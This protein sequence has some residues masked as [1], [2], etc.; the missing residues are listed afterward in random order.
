LALTP[1]A[2][3]EQHEGGRDRDSECEAERE[4][5]RTDQAAS[6]GR[7][8]RTTRAGRRF[9]QAKKAGRRIGGVTG[10]VSQV[11]AGLISVSRSERARV[12][13]A[14][15]SRPPWIS[16]TGVWTRSRKKNGE[17]EM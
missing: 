9:P 11:L 2:A 12:E 7:T 5:P 17:F 13:R 16:S 1:D 6:P 8:R 14:G 10:R 3:P 15:M 4:Q